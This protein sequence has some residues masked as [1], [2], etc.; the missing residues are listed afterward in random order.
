MDRHPLA[1]TQQDGR[2]GEAL[3]TG[4]LHRD[5]GADPALIAAIAEVVAAVMMWTLA[6]SFDPISPTG[7][8]MPPWSSSTN[9]WGSTCRISRSMG[10]ETALAASMTRLTSSRSMTRF[11]LLTAMTPRELKPLMWVPAIPT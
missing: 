5:D 1:A 2:V 8:A 7:E 11:L 9:S 4:T 6:S 10:I 3:G